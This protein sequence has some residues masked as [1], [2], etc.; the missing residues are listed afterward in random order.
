[1]P[2]RHDKASCKCELWKVTLETWVLE[3][4]RTPEMY[5]FCEA[6]EHNKSD[7][8]SHNVQTIRDLYRFRQLLPI[9]SIVSVSPTIA[10][11]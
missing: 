8:E 3:D 11:V 5:G 1:M 6:K 2:V 9:Y 10:S 4:L 7:N